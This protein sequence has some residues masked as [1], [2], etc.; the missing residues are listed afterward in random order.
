MGLLGQWL[1]KYA[2]LICAVLVVLSMGNAA[3]AQS[4]ASRIEEAL[5]NIT[6]LTRPERIG[7]ATVWDGNKYVQCRR[8]PDRNLRCEAAGMSMQPTLKRVLTGERLGKLNA[9]GWQL[10]PSFGNYVRIFPATM[11]TD[12]AAANILQVLSE[13]YDANV[14]E[15]EFRTAWI[16]D[17]PCPPRN[18]P[19]QNLAGMVNDA[20]AMQKRAVTSCSYTPAPA[21]ENAPSATALIAL[22]GPEVAAE[23]QR[24]R[25]N[26]K[27]KIFVVF[28]AG[29]GYVQCTTDSSTPALYCEAQSADSWPALASILTPER[30][31]LLIRA[32]Y[33]EPGRAPNYSKSYALDKFTDTAIA[34]EVLTLLHAVYGYSGATTLKI[35]TEQR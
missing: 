30:V 19:S 33:A 9:L 7:Y 21:P 10:D 18:G 27:Q 32:G 29:I 8:M 15:L 12:R 13:G 17:M 1:T 4:P 14:N 22:Y 34:T 16:K 2:G 31:T 28:D 3:L 26:I 35:K 5:Q 11:P 24:L 25:I 23:I 6:S 20:P